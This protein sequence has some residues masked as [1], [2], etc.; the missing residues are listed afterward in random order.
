MKQS[1]NPTV[2]SPMGLIKKLKRR[3]RT[4]INFL[5]FREYRFKRHVRRHLKKYY[6]P[7]A[8]KRAARQGL[9][10]SMADGRC[11]HGGLCDRLRTYTATYRYCMANGLPYAIYFRVPFRLEDYLEPN[12]YDWRVNDDEVSFNSEETNV[13]YTDTSGDAGERELRFR[14]KVYCKFLSD[15]KYCQ[16]HFYSS[17][18]DFGDEF[19]PTFRE[20]F[21]PN[22]RIQELIDRETTKIGGDYVS[23]ATR[24]LELLGDFREPKAKHRLSDYERKEL[25]A[26]CLSKIEDIHRQYPDHKI[27]VTSDSQRFVEE[28][29]RLPY[30]HMIEGHITHV[31]TTDSEDHTKTFLDFF[32]ISKAEK[33]FQLQLGPMYGGFFSKSA[34]MAGARPFERIN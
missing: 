34:A 11:H 3:L 27:L 32:M 18:S 14:E 20:L 4:E 30:V 12:S 31:D 2:I 29:S 21:R 16:H 26:A 25:I 8:P 17:F 10:I 23:V 9:V 15:K 7:D 22:E 24:F 6:S 1:T 33:V 13:L 28:A 19:G 5:F